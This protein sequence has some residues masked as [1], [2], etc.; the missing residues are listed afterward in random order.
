MS[1]STEVTKKL[2]AKL[3]ETNSELVELRPPERKHKRKDG[4]VDV[5]TKT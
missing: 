2:I 5:S 1:G 4:E 3:I